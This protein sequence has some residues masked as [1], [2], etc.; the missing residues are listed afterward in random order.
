[1][2]VV[3]DTNV[4]VSGLLSPMGAPGEVVRLVAAGEL[5]LCYDSRL[6]AEYRAVL[7]RPKFRFDQEYIEAVLD[8]LESLGSLVT[9]KPLG[10]RFPTLTIGLL[11]RLQLLAKRNT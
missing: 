8:Q 5:R 4:I 11:P 6:I 1:M 10:G 9:T 2:T 3:V 7:A